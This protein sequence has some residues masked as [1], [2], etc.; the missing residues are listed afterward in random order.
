MHRVRPKLM[1][2]YIYLYLRVV[3]ILKWRIHTNLPKAVYG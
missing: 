3:F 1:N 2:E